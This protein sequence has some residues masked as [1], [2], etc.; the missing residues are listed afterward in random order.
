[1]PDGE[2]P[3]RRELKCRQPEGHGRWHCDLP[4]GLLETPIGCPGGN[5]RPRCQLEWRAVRLGLLLDYGQ[6]PWSG[7]N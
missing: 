4:P 3:P 5:E 2:K 1:M 6:A 7:P